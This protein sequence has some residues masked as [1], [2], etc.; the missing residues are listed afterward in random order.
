VLIEM[1]GDML[2]IGI[3]C[4]VLEAPAVNVATNNALAAPQIRAATCLADHNPAYAVVAAQRRQQQ[5]EAVAVSTHSTSGTASSSEGSSPISSTLLSTSGTVFNTSVVY[6]EP[7]PLVIEQGDFH[8]ELAVEICD[9]L[10]DW[11]LSRSDTTALV[12]QDFTANMDYSPQRLRDEPNE[13]IGTVVPTGLNEDGTLKVSIA[14]GDV[15][16]C[17]ENVFPCCPFPSM[18]TNFDCYR[19]WVPS[20]VKFGEGGAMTFEF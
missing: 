15:Q 3:G 18:R 2:L 5:A 11:L 12:L 6:D 4:N 17:V 7:Q 19:P 8:K 9:N 20:C 1:E 14:F 16:M 10:H 13:A